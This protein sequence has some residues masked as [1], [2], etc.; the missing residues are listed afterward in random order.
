MNKRE[1]C[2]RK[3]SRV[4]GKLSFDRRVT[5]TNQGLDLCRNWRGGLGDG[6]ALAL[7]GM[8]RG[9]GTWEGGL[10][11]MTWIA[12]KSIITLRRCSSVV[13]CL[14]AQMIS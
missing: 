8:G 13:E 6:N 1:E 14:T 12:N 7:S 4:N 9:C 11:Y 3:G 5:P 2:P 10:S